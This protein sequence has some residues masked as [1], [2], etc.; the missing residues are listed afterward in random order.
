MDIVL[1]GVTGV[2][3]VFFTITGWELERQGNILWTA[4]HT[5]FILALSLILGI[6]AGMGIRFLFLFLEK[7]TKEEEAVIPQ[8][9]RKVWLISFG[10]LILARLPFLL[11]YYPGICA[12]DT[13]VQLG[14]VRAHEYNL[15]HPLAHTL[16]LKHTLDLGNLLSDTTIAMA[17]MVIGQVLFLSAVM[18]FGVAYLFQ[19]GVK[20]GWLIF[21]QLTWMAY[22]FYGF[23]NVSVTKDIVFAIFFLLQMIVLTIKLSG[24]K[25]WR[26]DVLFVA[27]SVLMQLYRNNGIYAFLVLEGFLFLGLLF[28]KKER[29]CMAWLFLEGA[30]SMVLGICVLAVLTKAMSAEQGDKREMLSVP[31][32]QMARCMIYH[33]GVGVLPQDDG[34]MQ[35]V[36]KALVND[37]LLYESYKNYDEKISDP[38][39][40]ST[41]TF[42]VRYRTM[43]FLRTYF[44][45]LK[46][47]PGDM[48]NAFLALN[49]G[50]VYM[51]DESHGRIYELRQMEGLSYV[52]T[53][54]D[55]I[56]EEYGIYRWKSFAGLRNVLTKWANDNGHLAIPGLKYL[57]VPALAFWGFLLILSNEIRRRNYKACFPLALVA[58]Y[59]FTLFLGPCV[60][61]RY[62]FP[63]LV[64]FPF[65]LCVG[66]MRTC[67]GKE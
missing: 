18:A 61:L 60:Q 12:Y 29:R 63:L 33:G 56:V 42:V 59:Y 66:R 46:R 13:S 64:V 22:P 2:L 11:A 47:Y 49:A 9:S 44:S 50:Y 20:R 52:H 34:T 53:R 62:L 30:V 65:S 31:I 4:G 5:A 17:L 14:Q 16:L 67:L 15:H 8:S 41:N 35:E 45:L 43:D 19:K 32:Q 26:Y 27:S 6:V 39:K 51:G 28:W 40:S 24:E 38:V 10:L 37:F 25:R 23:L 3:F 57:F 55:P 7:K 1:F 21:L 58:G 36:D 54:W 48:V